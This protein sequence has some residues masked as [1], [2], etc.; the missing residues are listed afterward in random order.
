MNLSPEKKKE[1][2][3]KH[4]IILPDKDIKNEKGFNKFLSQA[5]DDIELKSLKEIKKELGIKDIDIAEMFGY[6]NAH[7]YRT[8]KARDKMDKGLELFYHLIA[9]KGNKN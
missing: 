3:E 2:E 1:L 7:S 8:S 5:Y 4:N 9:N 6:A